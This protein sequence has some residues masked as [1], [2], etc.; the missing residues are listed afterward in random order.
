MDTK[1][2]GRVRLAKCV[3]TFR[4][5]TAESQAPRLRSSIFSSATSLGFAAL[6]GDAG[7]DEEGAVRP[8]EITRAAAGSCFSGRQKFRA[9]SK[10]SRP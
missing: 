5:V 9:S 10:V 2:I 1:H 6:E 7:V 8:G 3:R 4:P